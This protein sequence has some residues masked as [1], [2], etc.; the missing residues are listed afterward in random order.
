M[1]LISS[2][3]RVDLLNHWNELIRDLFPADAEF[4]AGRQDFVNKV[5][6]HWPLHDDPA[7]KHKASK[8]IRLLFKDDV[9][10]DYDDLSDREKRRSDRRLREF[11]IW[12]LKTHDPRHTEPVG[13]NPPYVE[14]IIT[15]RQ[16][17]GSDEPVFA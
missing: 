10:E 16:M 7:R 4:R 9:V 3:P 13:I 15:T 8:Y 12:K 17:N 6:I 5:V 2:E 14:W 11:V 1:T